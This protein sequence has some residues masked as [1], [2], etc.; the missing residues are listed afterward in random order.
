MSL[1]AAYSL[2]GCLVVILFKQFTGW[3]PAHDVVAHRVIWALLLLLPLVLYL[4]KFGKCLSILATPRLLGGLVLSSLLISTNWLVFVWAVE[5]DRVLESSLGYYILPLVNV[6]LGVVVLSER[7]RSAQSVSLLLVS[8]SVAAM[9]WLLGIIPW[10]P[11]VV[12]VS[13]AFYGLL[14]KILAVDHLEG[15]FIETALL[16]P[17]AL[18]WLV[19][20]AIVPGAMG[21]PAMGQTGWQEWLLLMSSG[22]GTA[23]PL[24]LFVYGVRRRSMTT[25][26]FTQY[27]NP[28]GQFLVAVFIYGELFSGWHLL[29]FSGIWVALVIFMVD[30]VRHEKGRHIRTGAR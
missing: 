12:A 23:I 13:F 15:L 30:L 9:L 29:I 26:G 16:S 28:T 2:W 17:V 11:L 10:I 20:R 5:T 3:A 25:V 7:L 8:V 4:G 19:W 18:L 27:I 14:H 6:L 22:A 24:L 21:I 1:V